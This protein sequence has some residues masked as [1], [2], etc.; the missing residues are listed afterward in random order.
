[1]K[2]KGY[3]TVQGHSR[4]SR[5]V[6]IES[7]Y[8]TS[9]YWLIVTDI[10]SRTISDFSQIIVQILDTAFLSSPLGD[11]GTM[12]D[13]HLGLTGKRIVN[14]GSKSAI[15]LQRW[16]VDSKFQVEGV[17]LHKPFFFSEN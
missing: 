12:Y 5:L 8:A 4:S 15:S 2:N 3:Y 17:A 11:L 16:P 13:V 1:M 7:P 9:H 14:I 10:L 6:S